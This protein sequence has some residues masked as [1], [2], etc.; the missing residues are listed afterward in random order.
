MNVL[1]RAF[2]PYG[3][4]PEA[5]PL[6]SFVQKEAR[7][8]ISCQRAEAYVVALGNYNSVK[9]AAKMDVPGAK[10]IYEDLR[11]RFEKA[12]TGNGNTPGPVSE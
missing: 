9:Q 4:M 5:K 12:K 1:N 2:N 7:D 3:Q 8:T 6:F 10:G 11:K